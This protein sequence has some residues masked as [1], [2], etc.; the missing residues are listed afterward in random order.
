MRNDHGFT[1]L[2]LLLAVAMGST[3]LAAAGSLWSLEA[4]RDKEAELLFA[5]DQIRSAIT[6][7]QQKAPAGQ[8]HAFPKSLIELLDDKR[9]PT[10]RRHLRKV[11]LDPMNARAEWG[12][13]LAPDGGVMGVYSLSEGVPLK[14]GLFPADYAIFE[15]AKSYRDWRFVHSVAATPAARSSAP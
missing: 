10:R 15:E 12:L 1:Y 3:A 8:A 7:Y 2:G 6:A 4:K 11:F 14:R 9:W 5:G 13:V